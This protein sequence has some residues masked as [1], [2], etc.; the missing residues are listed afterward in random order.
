MPQEDPP[1]IGTGMKVIRFITSLRNR[2]L[3]LLGFIIS[4]ALLIGSLTGLIQSPLLTAVK[5]HET[6][7]ETNKQLVELTRLQLYLARESCM[8]GAETVVEEARCDRQDIRSAII[9]D[10]LSA[11]SDNRTENLA[12]FPHAP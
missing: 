12:S 4:L 2:E 10:T 6:I 7:L 3:V 1:I 11:V 8:R 5:Q 9:G